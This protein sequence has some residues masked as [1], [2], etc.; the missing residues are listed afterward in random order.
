ML[1]FKRD[2]SIIKEDD[3]GDEFFKEQNQLHVSMSE[4]H[5]L[6]Q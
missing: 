5:D 4:A 3:D 1:A 6:I 2:F